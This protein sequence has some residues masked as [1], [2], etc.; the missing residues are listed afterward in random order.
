M[1]TLTENES[2]VAG[3]VLPMLV[4]DI[5][6]VLDETR[7]E[8]LPHAVGCCLREHA[9]VDGLLSRRQQAG[10]DESYT[11]HVLYAH[12]RG[13]CTVAALVWRPGQVTPVHGHYTWCSYMVLEG[14]M[15]EEHFAWDREKK[16]VTKTGQIVRRA[17][18]AVASHAG[19]E[20]IHRLRNAADETAIS[21][22]VYGVDAERIATHVNRI[23]QRA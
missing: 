5:R 1:L 3:S 2:P 20:Q 12:P 23:V 18:A 16:G 10:S 22:H 11:R 13:L 15:L 9:S 7:M 19:L 14:S 4:R 21:I 17:G 8:D 6:R